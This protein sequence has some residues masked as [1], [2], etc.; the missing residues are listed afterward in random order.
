MISVL[1]NAYP[2]VFRKIKEFAFKNN[3]AKGS[4]EQ[5]KLLDI[6]GPMYEEGS[7][8]GLKYLL[9]TMGI[10]SPQV[11]LPHAAASSALQKKITG[12]IAKR[13]G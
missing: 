5:F 11:R 7:P 2:Q 4:Q 1:A 3:F 9:S 8:I 13:K 6:N 12:I 10:C